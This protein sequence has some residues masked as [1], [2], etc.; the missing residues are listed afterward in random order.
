MNEKRKPV[1][2]VNDFFIQKKKKAIFKI[3]GKSWVGVLQRPSRSKV[4]PHTTIINDWLY[5]IEYQGV[6]EK[7]F[8]RYYE[9]RLTNECKKLTNTNLVKAVYGE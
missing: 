1:F 4:K 5:D 2:S 8:G 9:K 6:N 7:V 3:V